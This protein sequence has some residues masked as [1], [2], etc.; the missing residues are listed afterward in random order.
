VASYLSTYGSWFLSERETD[1]FKAIFSLKSLPTQSGSRTA[2]GTGDDNPIPLPIPYITDFS[3]SAVDI[4]LLSDHSLIE[5][6]GLNPRGTG[7]TFCPSPHATALKTSGNVLL[8]GFTLPW[9]QSIPPSLPFVMMWLGRA[10]VSVCSR[11]HLL[12]VSETCKIGLA[13]ASKTGGCRAKLIM[14]SRNS[15]ALPRFYPSA[16]DGLVKEIVL[17]T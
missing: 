5:A 1:F 2:E 4:D 15:C 9:I 7:F 16:G 11:Q 14:A 10:Y 6:E 12:T 3:I 8:G 13:V 17:E